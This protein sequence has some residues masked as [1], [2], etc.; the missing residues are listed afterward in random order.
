[1]NI[2]RDNKITGATNPFQITEKKE[3]KSYKYGSMMI[4]P[5]NRGNGGPFFLQQHPSRQ[6]LRAPRLFNGTPCLRGHMPLA[7][8]LMI[9][10]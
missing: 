4:S 5:I 2:Q 3:K 10:D 8:T 7:H 6:R 9:L 1:M